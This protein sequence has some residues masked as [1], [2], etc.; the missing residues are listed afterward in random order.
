MVDPFELLGLFVCEKT[1]S[2]LQHGGGISE[3]VCQLVVISPALDLPRYPVHNALHPPRLVTSKLDIRNMFRIPLPGQ[4]KP[5]IVGV[6]HVARHVGDH[7]GD[8]R[9]V[10]KKDGL[11]PMHDTA[12]LHEDAVTWCKIANRVHQMLVRGCDPVFDEIR[13]VSCVELVQNFV[14]SDKMTTRT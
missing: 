10:G 7:S 1:L 3:H 6:K 8:A 11:N 4:L 2:L 13:V 14:R 5:C 12:A 9:L